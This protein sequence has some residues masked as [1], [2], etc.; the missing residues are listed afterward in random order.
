LL[1]PPWSL[2]RVL[3]LVP[4]AVRDVIYSFIARNRLRFFGKLETCYM[5]EVQF[6]DRVL[7]GG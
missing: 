2:A 5:P 6:R 4:M 1:G 3:R 7:N